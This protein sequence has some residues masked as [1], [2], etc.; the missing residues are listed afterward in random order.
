MKKSLLAIVVGALA[1]ASTANA[2][3]YAEGD[4]GLSRTKL[5]NGG[6]SKTKV[7]PR[8]AVGYKLGN[9]RVAGDYTHHGNFQGTK[10]QGLGA[11]VFYDFDTNSQI[12]PYVGARLAANRFKFEERA[13]Q[14]YKSSS[15]TK[16]GYGVVAGA[17]YKL[18]E[19]VY[20]NGG[21]EYNRL[22][23]FDDT[24]VNNYGAKVG[25]GYEFLI[26]TAL[27]LLDVKIC[28]GLIYL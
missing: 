2:G 24:K 20:A 4:L 6:S 18:A 14:R 3:L 17:K 15:E 28:I 19:K 11:T 9:M 12:E 5:S 22:G 27:F 26:F 10:V 1:V 25:V 13:D 7:E 8:V 16:V 23:S 21:L